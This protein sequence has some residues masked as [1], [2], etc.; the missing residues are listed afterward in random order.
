MLGK[1]LGFEGDLLDISAQ[2]GSSYESRLFLGKVID[3]AAVVTAFDTAESDRAR[4]DTLCND[5]TEQVEVGRRDNLKRAELLTKVAAL[6]EEFRSARAFSDAST[7]LNNAA[8]DLEAAKNKR[9][10]TALLFEPSR[11]RLAAAEQAF[12]GAQAQML[13]STHLVDGQP[14][15][16]C[17]SADH[18]APAYGDDDPE[19]LEREMNDL[20]KRHD[21]IVREATIAESA[22]APAEALVTERTDALAEL[23]PPRAA[24]AMIEKEG[25]QVADDLAA[26]GTA[27]DLAPLESNLAE[28]KRQLADAMSAVTIS[29]GALQTAK[30]AEAVAARSYQDAISSVPEALRAEGAL[31][32][33]AS[34]LEQEIVSLRGAVAAAG[35]RRQETANIKAAAAAKLTGASAAVVTA[36]EAASKARDAFTQR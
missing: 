3:H 2:V 19:R 11:M 9:D 12:I 6:R 20:R 35:K 4:L 10:Q 24:M 31:D 22:I 26:L 36:R 32:A 15:P 21:G 29:C 1:C 30:T 13:A 7:R 17:G 27:I 25:T 33:E 28:S 8:S 23:S 18:P 34:R 5:L 16:V 14:C